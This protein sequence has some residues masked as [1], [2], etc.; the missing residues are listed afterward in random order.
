MKNK[1]YYSIAIIITVMFALGSAAYSVV[2]DQGASQ[3]GSYRPAFLA[4]NVLPEN[5][6]EDESPA[7]KNETVY[8][9]LDHY[10]AVLDQR[11][12]NRIYGQEIPGADSVFDYGVYTSVENMITGDEPAI[13][14]NRIIWDSQLL[15]NEDIY[16]EGTIKQQLPVDIT[17]TYYLDGIEIEPENLAGKSGRLELLIKFKNNLSYNEPLSYYDYEGNLV[18]KQDDNYVPLLVQGTLDADLNLYSEIDPGNGMSLIMG[19]TASIN[20]MVFPY[21]EDEIIISMDGIDIELE[22]TTFMIIPQM[23]AVPDVDIEDMLIQMLEGIRMFSEGFGE[24]SVGADRILQGLIRFNDE[25]K[26]MTSGFDDLYPV[27]EEYKAQRENLLGMLDSRD[28]EELLNSIDTL[29]LMLAE[30]ENIPDGSELSSELNQAAVETEELGIQLDELNRIFSGLEK[31]SRQIT[32]EAEKLINENEPGT[33]LHEL[34]LLLI[35]REE[36]LQSASYQNYLAGQSFS[37]LENNLDS[38]QQNWLNN[39]MPGLNALE[40]LN[41]LLKAGDIP[42]RIKSFRQEISKLNEYLEMADQFIIESDS[43]LAEIA[44]LPEALDQM[45]A[46][47]KRLTDGINALRSEGLKAMEE[48]LIEGINESRAGK[49]KIELMKKLADDYR[50]YADNEHNRSSEVR[51]IIQTPRIEIVNIDSPVSVDNNQDSSERWT[52]NILAKFVNLFQ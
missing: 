25:S 12:V 21:P 3:D 39:Y 11:I 40:E 31:S 46:G 6:N 44:M 47:Q 28:I 20:F 45:V 33:P 19:H 1:I 48:G 52:E 42:D 22:R 32:V 43:M 17:I 10:G 51:F 5:P 30:I 23:P 50:S 16:Y 7:V 8:V 49:A 15:K 18:T 26:R 2:P 37:A 38:F 41:V 29:E 9:L 27:I 36:E 14:D 13:I 24:L 34:G 4:E 35:V